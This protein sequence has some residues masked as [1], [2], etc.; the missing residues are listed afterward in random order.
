ME[1]A[2]F[3]RGLLD[4]SEEALIETADDFSKDYKRL[5]QMAKC[6][7]CAAMGH[8]TAASLEETR[9]YRDFKATGT[10]G[11]LSCDIA[12]LILPLL[13]DHVLREAKQPP[14]YCNDCFRFSNMDNHAVIHPE[15]TIISKSAGERTIP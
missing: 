9:K 14:N 2:L 4:P 8:M 6:R 7:D 13:A 10:K 12:S 3:I 11:I 15:T 5:L 1:H